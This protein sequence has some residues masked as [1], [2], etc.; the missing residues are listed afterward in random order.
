MIKEL[1]HQ[2]DITILNIYVPNY[3]PSNIFFKLSR[4]FKIE[5]EKSIKLVEDVNILLSVFN[6]KIA[7][8]SI[9][10]P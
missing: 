3:R 2:E 9:V 10:R 6:R 4:T 7:R 8:K 5:I 1:I